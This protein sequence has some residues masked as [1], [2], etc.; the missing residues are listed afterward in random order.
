MRETGDERVLDVIAEPLR[1]LL[2]RDA[3]FFE[4][5]DLVAG[6]AKLGDDHR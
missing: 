4:R 1:D 2:G 5:G 6:I 3:G